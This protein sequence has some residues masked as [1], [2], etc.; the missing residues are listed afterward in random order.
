VGVSDERRLPLIA[1]ALR[2]LDSVHALVVHGAGMDEVSP[3]GPTRV[4]EVREGAIA[5]WVI[6][7]QRFGF[8]NGSPADIAGGPP[9]ENAA[10]VLRVLRGDANGA[11]IAAVVLNAAAAFYVAGLVTDFGEGVDAARDA[12]AS[13]AGLVA[14]ERLRAAFAQK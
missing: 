12:I 6:D 3:F 14:L 13:G 8:G 1:G 5:E 9:A 11:S 2:E 7:P 4:L 10:A